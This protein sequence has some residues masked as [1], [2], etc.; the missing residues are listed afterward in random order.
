MMNNCWFCRHGRCKQCMV[1]IPQYEQRGNA[2]CSFN[3]KYEKCE[4]R[5]N[6]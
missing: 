1:N 3:T 2:E 6:V 5:H 4:C